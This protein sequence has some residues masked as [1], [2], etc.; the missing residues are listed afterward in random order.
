MKKNKTK[1][2]KNYQNKRKPSQSAVV[3]KH[4]DHKNVRITDSKHGCVRQYEFNVSSHE[5]HSDDSLVLN[6]SK[7]YR[8][9]TLRNSGK[10][11]EIAYLLDYTRSKTKRSLT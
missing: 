9:S 2:S 6:R 3:S 7:A 1:T 8:Q 5:R 10:F 11:R 4:N